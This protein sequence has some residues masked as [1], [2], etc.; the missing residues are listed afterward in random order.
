MNM[1]VYE[2]TRYQNIYRNIKNKNY[3]IMM[4]KPVKTSI[5]RIDSKKIFNIDDAIKI[6]DNYLLKKQ[7]GLETIHKESI[8]FLWKKYIHDGVYIKKW[9]YNTI[10]RKNKMANRYIINL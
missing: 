2:K 6:R 9:A 1:R 3:V 8:D 7:K 5:S 10:T 4:S